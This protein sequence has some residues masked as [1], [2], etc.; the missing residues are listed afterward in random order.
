[1]LDFEQVKGREGGLVVIAEVVEE[2]VGCGWGGD[3]N[4]GGGGVKGYEVRGV[5]EEFAVG[6]SGVEGPEVDGVVEGAGEEFITAGG[7]GQAGHGGGVAFEVAEEE[8]V[9]G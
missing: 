5:E 9:V 7:D 2:D 4:Y 8:V 6:V 3:C 1:L